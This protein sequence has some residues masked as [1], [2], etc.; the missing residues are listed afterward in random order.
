MIGFSLMIVFY[1]YQLLESQGMFCVCECLGY[2]VVDVIEI[3]GNIGVMQ[4]VEFVSVNDF[5]FD[6]LQVFCDLY[7]FSLGFVYLDLFFYF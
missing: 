7:M 4:F 3:I 5:V 6:V 1:V 2:W